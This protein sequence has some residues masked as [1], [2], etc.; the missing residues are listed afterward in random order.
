MRD[1]LIVELRREAED[2]D[3]NMTQKLRLIA[4]K[5]VD[6]AIEGDVGAI[7]EIADRTDG[8]PAQESHVT[9]RKQDAADYSDDELMEVIANARNGSA[10]ASGAKE[11]VTKPDRVH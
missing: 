10:R 7:K 3:G 6:K 5:L 11:S 1:A 4:R 8:K 2:A 9:V